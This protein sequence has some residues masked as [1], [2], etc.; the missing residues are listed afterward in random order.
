M[1]TDTQTDIDN[2]GNY[3]GEPI[4]KPA[5]PQHSPLPWRIDSETPN[6]AP[7]IT[8]QDGH[9]R[10]IAEIRGDSREQRALNAKL[11]VRAVNHADKLAELCSRLTDLLEK[12][13]LTPHEN[14][15]PRHDLCVEGK[16]LL[17]VQEAK[18]ALAA[19]EEARGK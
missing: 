17:V 14:G 9:G 12:H 8:A 10:D 6:H 3:T 16:Y 11:I 2:E 15:K 7:I 5:K 13:S 1:N 19:Y 4:L 18:A